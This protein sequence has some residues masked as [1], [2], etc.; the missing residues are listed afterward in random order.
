MIQDAN[1][2]LYSKPTGQLFIV[3][4]Q[5]ANATLYSHK[6][7]SGW[8]CDP[9]KGNSPQKMVEGGGK[10]GLICG[11][12]GRGKQPIPSHPYESPRKMLVLHFGSTSSTRS[13]EKP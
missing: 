8:A 1:A 3:L 13:M 12:M 6:R 2:T 7:R 10:A 5:D 11:P 9:S 4:I